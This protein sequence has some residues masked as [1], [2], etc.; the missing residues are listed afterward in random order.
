MAT[1]TKLSF[2]VTC[3]AMLLST[4]GFA[5]ERCR[6]MRDTIACDYHPTYGWIQRNSAPRPT[7]APSPAPGNSNA[8]PRASGS[9]QTTGAAPTA[10]WMGQAGASLRDA[11]A[12][13]AAAGQACTSEVQ[14]HFRDAG[15]AL[16][17]LEDTGNTDPCYRLCSGAARV[18]N[19]AC[20]ADR[21]ATEA[22][23]A[24][25]WRQAV[26]QSFA[27]PL[28]RTGTCACR[29]APLALGPFLEPRALQGDR[30]EQAARQKP[31]AGR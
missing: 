26:A 13:A 28:D 1:R 15:A 10:V 11:F 12:K 14:G 16:R 23:K 5:Q 31:M 18:G 29:D 17:L 25:L 6:D 2:V 4:G 7:V 22:E 3:L 24:A 8:P 9:G 21:A 27:V 20:T 19:L 30:I